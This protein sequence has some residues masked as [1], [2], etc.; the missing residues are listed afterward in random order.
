MEVAPDETNIAGK[1]RGTRISR[2]GRFSKTECKVEWSSVVNHSAF[3]PES[4]QAKLENNQEESN[5]NIPLTR[6]AGEVDEIKIRD[7]NANECVAQ[8]KL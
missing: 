8:S 2:D 5:G 1:D 3:V 4:S 6:I 7:D